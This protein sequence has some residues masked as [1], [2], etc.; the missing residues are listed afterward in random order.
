[1][2]SS[3]MILASILCRIDH[4]LKRF[5]IENVVMSAHFVILPLFMIFEHDTVSKN[6]LQ[7]IEIFDPIEI[8]DVDLFFQSFLESVMKFEL[9][10]QS[11]VVKVDRQ[12][13]IALFSHRAIGMGAEKVGEFDIGIV[14]QKVLKLRFHAIDYSTA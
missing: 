1:M 6:R 3:Q 7:E 10:F 14:G 8:D 11:V 9:F 5:E 12:V 13:R 4:L 2:A